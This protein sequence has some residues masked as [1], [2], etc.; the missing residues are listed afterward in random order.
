M[1]RS[2]RWDIEVPFHIDIDV[3]EADIDRLQHVNNAVY[4]RFLEQA[5]WAH[6]EAL[7]LDW[8]TYQ[9]LDAACVVRRHELDYLLPAELGDRLQ[10]ATWIVDND[11]RLTMWRAFQIRRVGDGRTLLRARTQYV[12]VGLSNGRPKRMPQ[13]FVDAYRPVAEAGG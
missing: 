7:G 12:T 8:T 2:D 1:P 11:G 13:R 10:V 4:L 9:A 6:T 3:L 5:A